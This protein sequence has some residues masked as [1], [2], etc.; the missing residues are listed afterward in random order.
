MPLKGRVAERLKQAAKN[1]PPGAPND[2]LTNGA[3]GVR[4]A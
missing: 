1:L 2:R 4:R 3:G